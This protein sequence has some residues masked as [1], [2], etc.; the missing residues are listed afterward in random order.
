[1]TQPQLLHLTVSQ[2]IKGIQRVAKEETGAPIVIQ[3]LLLDHRISTYKD[4]L[5]SSIQCTIPLLFMGGKIADYQ[6][7]LIQRQTQKGKTSAWAAVDQA[8]PSD[9]VCLQTMLA[10][11]SNCQCNTLC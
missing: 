7:M 4:E 11:L 3:R 1:M 9:L 6:P 8:V 2:L 5:R 10:L